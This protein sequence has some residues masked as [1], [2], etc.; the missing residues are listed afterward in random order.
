MI[1]K[2]NSS[3]SDDSCDIS[4][5]ESGPYQIIIQ[6]FVSSVIPKIFSVDNPVSVSI[7]LTDDS[8]I[9]KLNKEYRNVDS[10]TDV[11][12]FEDGFISP[13][14][15]YHA[16]E[17]AVSVPYAKR[18]KDNRTLEQYILFLITHGLLHLSGTHHE[19]EEER[20]E[21]IEIGEKILREYNE[22]HS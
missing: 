3:N 10:E 20:E 18:T 16:G 8:E 19:T 22:S 1:E 4:G 13:D 11:L 5:P 12:S 9:Q 14:G 21:V 2:T 7:H 15:I 17:I 6:D